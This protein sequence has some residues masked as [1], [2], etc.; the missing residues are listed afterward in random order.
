[1]AMHPAQLSFTF[2]HA[3]AQNLCCMCWQHRVCTWRM[4]STLLAWQVATKT[5]PSATAAKLATSMEMSGSVISGVSRSPT[6]TISHSIQ[7]FK[8][9]SYQ[10]GI[11]MLLLHDVHLRGSPSLITGA[12]I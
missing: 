6:C 2:G 5:R 10:L 1:M 11:I 9:T 4:A 8:V 12:L 3:I 7:E